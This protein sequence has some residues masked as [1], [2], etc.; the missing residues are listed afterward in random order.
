MRGRPVSQIRRIG[1]VPVA[2]GLGL[3]SAGLLV[4]VHGVHAAVMVAAGP[5]AATAI[6]F[7]CRIH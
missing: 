7:V 2:G 5:A 4:I 1:R 3:G 6:A